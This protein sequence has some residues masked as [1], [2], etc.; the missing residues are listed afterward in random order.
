MATADVGFSPHAGP[1]L[2]SNG[3]IFLEAIVWAGVADVASNVMKPGFRV[4]ANCTLN[5]VYVNLSV[6]PVGNSLTVV[7]TSGG[8]TIA[9]CQVSAGEILGLAEGLVVPLTKN[10]ILGVDVTT[11]GTTTK[12]SDVL[13]SLE[14]V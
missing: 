5:A 6:A 8:T 4:P 9:T 14:A 12:G 13:V 2:I 11:V 10:D 3:P 7:I 1:T